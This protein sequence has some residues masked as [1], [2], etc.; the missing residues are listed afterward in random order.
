MSKMKRSKL[1]ATKLK[2]PKK[3]LKDPCGTTQPMLPCGKVIFSSTWPI[4]K[5]QKERLQ[6][7]VYLSEPSKQWANTWKPTKSGWCTSTLRLNSCT[8][9]SSTYST[10][11]LYRLLSSNMRRY[12]KGKLRTLIILQIPWHDRE[13]SQCNNWRHS[14]WPVPTA[15]EVRRAIHRTW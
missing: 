14:E 7:K 12:L 4:L 15:W 8:G 6:Q 13:L 2:K 11:W 9:A 5:A 1:R 3:Y 10:S